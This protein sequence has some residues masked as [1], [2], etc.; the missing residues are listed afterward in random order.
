MLV[1]NKVDTATEETRQVQK[2]E[3]EEYASKNKILF[4]ETSALSDININSAFIQLLN[5]I[6]E[7]KIHNPKKNNKVGIGLKGVDA[8][9][10]EERDDG[11]S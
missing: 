4:C 8:D 10:F 11:C 2:Q 3:A 7:V 1:G 9:G 6:D 5:K